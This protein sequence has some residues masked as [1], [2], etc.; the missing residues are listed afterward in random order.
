[1]FNEHGGISGRKIN[2]IS[3]DDGYSRGATARA[4]LPEP[5]RTFGSAPSYYFKD[6]RR[7]FAITLAFAR[8]GSQIFCGWGRG[9]GMQTR[10]LTV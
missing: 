5:R 8:P 4:K 7:S 10:S 2:L 6:R 9:C 1:M 3:R